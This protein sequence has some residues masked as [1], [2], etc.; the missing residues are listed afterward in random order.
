MSAAP[1]ARRGSAGGIDP[2]VWVIARGISGRAPG[3]EGRGGDA[4]AHTR[5]GS[6]EGHFR[7]FPLRRLI[8]LEVVARA[9]VERRGDEVGGEGLAALLVAA[10]GVVVV[11]AGEAD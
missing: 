3:A 6:R 9:E 11:L 1:A 4:P 10:D 8:N 5:T 2:G 7:R